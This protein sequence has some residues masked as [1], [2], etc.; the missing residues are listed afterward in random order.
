MRLLLAVGVAPVSEGQLMYPAAPSKGD[1]ILDPFGALQRD[2][3][4]AVSRNTD[5]L[6]FALAEL[7]VQILHQQVPAA[8]GIGRGRADPVADLLA[9]VADLAALLGREIVMDQE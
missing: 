5:H 3:G 7:A 9:L 1:V 2:G 4:I 6:R 8:R